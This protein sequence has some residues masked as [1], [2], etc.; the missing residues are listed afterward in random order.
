M[1]A[2][3]AALFVVLGAARLAARAMLSRSHRDVAGFAGYGISALALVVL[4]ASF[5][6]AP[7]MWSS[8]GSI[9]NRIY[10]GE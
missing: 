5:V 6:L 4:A 1:L 3:T 8:F 7:D 9:L 2:V 10:Q